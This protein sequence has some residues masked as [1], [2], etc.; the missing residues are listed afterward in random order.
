M[1]IGRNYQQPWKVTRKPQSQNL[2]RSDNR[3]KT[4]IPSNRY[5]SS[6]EE[7]LPGG[8]FFNSLI[9]SFRKFFA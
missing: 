7:K 1:R 4:S 2:R 3:I 6:V 9:A 5:S 8:N